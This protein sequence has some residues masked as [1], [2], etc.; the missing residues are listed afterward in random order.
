M[1]SPDLPQNQ[2]VYD[3]K[4]QTS[5]FFSAKGEHPLKKWIARPRKKPAHKKTARKRAVYGKSTHEDQTFFPVH[6]RFP[7]WLPPTGLVVKFMV[8]IYRICVK[9]KFRII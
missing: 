8:T 6:A 9:Y 7:P 4:T 2:T 5:G 3:R 1:S